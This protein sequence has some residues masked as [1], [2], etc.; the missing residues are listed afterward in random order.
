MYNC[1]IC[2]SGY[3]LHGTGAF[4]I[5]GDEDKWKCFSCGRGGD[6]FDLIGELRHAANYNKQLRAAADHFGIIIDDSN[7]SHRQDFTPIKGTAVVIQ[8]QIR[9]IPIL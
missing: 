5:N 4:S 7:T 8:S 6:I 3:G 2:G 1:P 9:T